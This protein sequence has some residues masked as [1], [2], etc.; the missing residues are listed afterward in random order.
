MG[1]LRDYLEES[2]AGDPGHAVRFVNRTV[3]LVKIGRHWWRGYRKMT[4]GTVAVGGQTVHEGA[5]TKPSWKLLP[6]EVAS[7]FAAFERAVDE[8]VARSCV[9]ATG[10]DGDPLVFGSGVYAVDVAQ[11]P[12]LALKLKALQG[13]WDEAADKWCTADGYKAFHALLETQVGAA[14]YERIKTLVPK[15]EVLRGR[16]WLGVT[17][18]AFRLSEDVADPDEERGRG[19][20]VVELLTAAVQVPREEAAATW[21][22]LA[23]QLV[24]LENGALVAHRPL[25]TNRDGTV[26]PTAR[27]VNYLSVAA[28]RRAADALDR[29]ERFHDPD[30]TAALAAVKSETATDKSVAEQISRTLNAQDPAALRVARVLTAAATVAADEARM[31]LGAARALAAV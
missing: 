22:G 27:R 21:S 20:A 1:K 30:L 31:C 6:A 17:P 26:S 2:Y 15:A 3:R 25:K 10:S 29:C 14:E 28:A 4:D 5:A 9:T 8:L 7:E 12:A 11:W 24:A 23:A 19:A 18:L 13:R 16:F